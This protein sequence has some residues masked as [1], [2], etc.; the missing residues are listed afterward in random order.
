MQICKKS[1]DDHQ[2][3]KQNRSKSKSITEYYKS[4]W[5][6]KFCGSH[7]YQ[8]AGWAQ[9]MKSEKLYILFMSNWKWKTSIWRD[10]LSIWNQWEFR[11]IHIL[12]YHLNCLCW[13][14]G[15][16][17]INVVLWNISYF[18]R[19]WTVRREFVSSRSLAIVWRVLYCS[20]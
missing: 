9:H 6:C 13:N 5:C 8:C 17:Y 18:A 7:D 3:S 10:N 4:E 16:D 12:L 11:S 19:L 14:L 20:I 15:F 1:A 2:K